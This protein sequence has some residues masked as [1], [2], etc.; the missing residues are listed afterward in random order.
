MFQRKPAAD[1]AA[2][3]EGSP[4]KKLIR[5]STIDGMPEDLPDESWKPWIV[6]IIFSQIN[7]LV[8][9]FIALAVW[10]LGASAKYNASSEKLFSLFGTD[11]GYLYL[12]VFL[13]VN[14]INWVIFYPFAIKNSMKLKS[15]MRANAYI[16]AMIGEGALPNKIVLEEEG[17][18]GRY[19][20]ATRSMQHM[21][22]NLISFIPCLLLSGIVAPFP[23]LVCVLLWSVGRF[24]YQNGYAGRYGK[25]GAGYGIS[26]VGQATCQGL[27]LVV[28]LKSQGLL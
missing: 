23:V 1:K 26:S 24:M 20:R 28:F 13:I 25:H 2:E 12:A 16:Y 18:I 19:N 4:S 8:G 7:A 22:E 5:S 17:V 3:A 15:N 14:A 21:M 9:V 10:Y 27:V 6:A 11:I